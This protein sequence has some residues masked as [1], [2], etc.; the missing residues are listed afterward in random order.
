[1]NKNHYDA[2]NLIAQNLNSANI[3]LKSSTFNGK[4]YELDIFKVL[5]KN[6]TL[7]I[8]EQQLLTRFSRNENGNDIRLKVKKNLRV[9]DTTSM[10]SVVQQA[11]Q[12]FIVEHVE[13]FFHATMSD[14]LDLKEQLDKSFKGEDLKIREKEFASVLDNILFYFKKPSKQKDSGF[15]KNI[16]YVYRQTIK[17]VINLNNLEEKLQFSNY[18]NTFIHSRSMNRKIKVFIG[19]TNSGKTYAAFE[20]L[21]KADTG[22]YL[23]PLRLLAHEG[24]DKLFE[25]AVLSSIITG[26][27]RKV[28]PGAT[29]ICSTIEM[30]QLNKTFDCVVIDEIQMLADP[31]RGWAWTQALVGVQAKELILVGS[32]EIMPILEP[33]LQELKEPYEIVNF[34]RK[35]E[36]KIGESLNSNINNLQDGDCL[37][38]FNR[39]D[40]LFY[41]KELS[42]LGKPCSVIYGNLSPELRVAEARKFNSGKNKILIATDAIGMGLNLPIKRVFFSKIKKFNGIENTLIEPSLIKQIAGRAGRYGIS[43]EAGV[44][45]TLDSV[46][47]SYIKNC[48]NKS[49]P[50]HAEDTRCFIQPNTVHIEEICKSLNT[51]SIAPALIFFREKMVNKSKFFKPS[52][53]DDMI[54]LSKFIDKYE[55]DIK[56]AYLYCTA[57]VDTK[58]E[59]TFAMFKNWLKNAKEGMPIKSPK[60]PQGVANNVVNDYNLFQAE[61]YIKTINVY[62]WLN[63]HWPEMYY[64]MTELDKNCKQACQYIESILSTKISKLSNTLKRRR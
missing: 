58:N 62:K 6:V 45:S 28:Y 1:M 44:V 43:D 19:P 24:A 33:L 31:Q 37:I 7:T 20:C 39:K 61:N 38:V 59:D 49:Y 54:Y 29:H 12:L 32:P 60:L 47:L 40:A 22:A 55:L 9:Q 3:Y 53:L 25:R 18:Q 15:A 35:N 42:Q 11:Q 41:K 51:T 17:D 26:E 48:I 46:D 52:H 10:E 23:A 57:P 36:L 21:K 13:D 50:T 2:I 14:L 8:Q 27:E 4:F 5:K 56:S 64:D 63:N 30:A 34:E 16:L